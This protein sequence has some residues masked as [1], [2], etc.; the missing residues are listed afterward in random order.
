M[1]VLA[2]IFIGFGWWFTTSQHEKLL[3]VA[4]ED[5]KEHIAEY[6]R[7]KAVG[8]L[9]PEIFRSNDTQEQD[10]VFSNYWSNIQSPEYVRIKI[11]DTNFTLIWADMKELIGQRFPDNHEMVDALEG[12]IELEID[13]FGGLEN[14]KERQ[15]FK[16]SEVYVPLYGP[17][18]KE[19]IG[20]VE[21]YKTAHFIEQAEQ[22]ILKRALLVG[23]ALLS[24]YALL[25]VFLYR[26]FRRDELSST[27]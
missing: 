5:E 16:T 15:L 25:G 18:G 10:R 4:M 6:L 22:D 1:V 9:S 3:Q 14:E 2:F 26:F 23:I 13:N 11:W 7:G 20:V 24:I 21:I 27:L 8:V 19:V 12:G 17:Q